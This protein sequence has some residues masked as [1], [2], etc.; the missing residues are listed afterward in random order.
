MQTFETG[1][2]DLTA[3]PL[4]E[5]RVLHEPDLDFAI[6][7]ERRRAEQ[8]DEDAVQIQEQPGFGTPA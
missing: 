5:L 6:A 1:L 2:L 3:I 7:G 8:P 4:G